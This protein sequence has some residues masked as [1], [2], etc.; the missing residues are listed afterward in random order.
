M[1]QQTQVATFTPHVNGCKVCKKILRWRYKVNTLIP[2][3]DKMNDQ[4]THEYQPPNPT[5]DTAIAIFGED[6]LHPSTMSYEQAKSGIRIDPGFAGSTSFFSGEWSGLTLSYGYGADRISRQVHLR[7]DG[8]I[9]M[10][11]ARKA[12]REMEEQISAY[13]TRLQVQRESANV[14]SA[15]L[16]RIRTNNRLVF[17]NIEVKDHDGDSVSVT[18][19]PLNEE[20]AER[21]IGFFRAM[22]STDSEN[23]RLA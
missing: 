9:N 8:T 11:K 13:E 4:F 14:V 17:R 6:N 5:R 16:A 3:H 21:M 1:P 22:K 19:W 15:R 18:F 10:I 20:E 2:E 23:T 7:K 12:V